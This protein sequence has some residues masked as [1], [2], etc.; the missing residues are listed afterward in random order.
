MGRRRM[1]TSGIFGRSQVIDARQVA[2]GELGDVEE[3]GRGGVGGRD[4]G[5]RVAEHGVAEGAG[6]GDGLRAGGGQFAGADVADA[7]VA[8]LFAE[9]GESAA[10]SAAEAALVVAR[11]FDQGGLLRDDGA[12][13]GVDGLVAAEVAGVVVDNRVV[14][15][16]W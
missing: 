1:C 14:S 3:L 5:E 9:E 7:G 11:G 6:G 4:G 12:G 13:F 8:L 15:G 2:G 10:G 16:Q